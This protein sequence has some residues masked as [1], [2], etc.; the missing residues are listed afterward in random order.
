[1][2]QAGGSSAVEFAASLLNLGN[3]A[4]VS[5]NQDGTFSMNNIGKTVATLHQLQDAVFPNVAHNFHDHKWLCQRAIFSPKK[6]M[7][8][9]PQRPSYIVTWHFANVIVG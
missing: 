3:G 2:L 5:E 7:Q 1:M 4:M 9:I 6:M 8:P